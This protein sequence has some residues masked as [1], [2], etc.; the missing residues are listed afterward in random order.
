VI[1]QL[2]LNPSNVTNT[3]PVSAVTIGWGSLCANYIF[4]VRLP[5]GSNYCAGQVLC[6]GTLNSQGSGSC[7]FIASIADGI[8]YNIAACVDRNNN[9]NVT[10]STQN[11]GE[12]S[13]PTFLIV[14]STVS[15]VTAS[16]FNAS[17]F[18][19]SQR[20][21]GG[22]YNCSLS[23]AN[24]FNE[25]AFVIY[26]VS[27]SSGN[28][29]SSIAFMASQGSG[30]AAVNYFCKIPGNYTMSWQAY[31]LSDANLATPVSYSNPADRQFMN[32]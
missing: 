21:G 31:R 10:G 19:C 1:G 24:A 30:T 27:D 5:V 22:S 17:R 13:Y 26:I 8:Y 14:N 28:T 6:A 12:Q 16:T 3:T 11:A 9:G 15:S 4:S 18:A 23:F 2:S 7:S 32:C 25:S 20:S 29:A